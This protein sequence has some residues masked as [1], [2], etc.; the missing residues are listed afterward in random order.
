MM[1]YEWFKDF[2]VREFTVYGEYFEGMPTDTP[3][4][5]LLNIDKEHLKPFTK[6]IL[7]LTDQP[8]DFRNV[9]SELSR[10]INAYFQFQDILDVELDLDTE[11]VNRHYCYFESLMYLRESVVS[12][13]D[14]NVLAGLTLL[15]P[16][17][18]L[19]LL[20]IYWYLKCSRKTYVKYYEWLK[21]GKG[22]PPFQN[23]L[24]YIFEHLPTIEQIGKTRADELKNNIQYIY[25]S[26]C[27]YNHTPKL[28]DSIAAKSGGFGN[29]HYEYFLFYIMTINILMHQLIYLYI[30]AY[31]M[32]LFPVNKY[33]KWGFT[34]YPVG[35]FFDRMNYAILEH[36]V[37]TDNINKLKNS[38]KD[39]S[40][41]ISLMQWFNSQPILTEEQIENSWRQV[42]AR[43]PESK[44]K[45]AVELGER[46]ALIK[47]Y[48]RS[49]QWAQNYVVEDEKY[50]DI[51]DEVLER[52]R[53]RVRN[54]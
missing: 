26:L 31:P 52:D 45:E 13:L 18:E 22:K 32:S 48:D 7:N 54:W 21:N 5:A 20:H 46:I 37:D 6:D 8:D 47:S 51:P 43:H 42:I 16:F 17:L 19:A 27:S 15:R 25:K 50:R 38:L 4:E 40:D 41:V 53:K 12:W 2:E 33:E 44:M 24:N 35:L 36:F 28:E 1:I 11:M 9:M 29:V 30:L 34:D 23:S 39:A 10:G 14:R 3:L 49:L